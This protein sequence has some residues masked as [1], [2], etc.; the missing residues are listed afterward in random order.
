MLDT[1][2]DLKD[3]RLSCQIVVSESGRADDD[4]ARQI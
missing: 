3:P 4:P 2:H 1:A